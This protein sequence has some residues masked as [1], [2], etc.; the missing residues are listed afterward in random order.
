LA[1]SRV[2][3]IDRVGTTPTVIYR[4]NFSGGHEGKFVNSLIKGAKWII[5]DFTECNASAAVDATGD[6]Q[7]PPIHYFILQAAYYFLNHAFVIVV[8]GTPD[9][10]W[11]DPAYAASRDRELK[12]KYPTILQW[13]LH[14]LDEELELRPNRFSVTGQVLLLDSNS[15]DLKAYLPRSYFSVSDVTGPAMIVAEAAG[16]YVW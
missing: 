14:L 10:E 1:P 15:P 7:M 8:A 6:N 3:Q 12:E 9:P 2:V 4:C 13:A 11:F 16:K 5:Y